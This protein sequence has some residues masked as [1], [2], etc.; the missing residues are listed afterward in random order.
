M[1]IHPSI[2]M[3][4]TIPEV[5]GT[6]DKH[7]WGVS[8]SKELEDGSI[9]DLLLMCGSG[10]E[11]SRPKTKVEAPLFSL[12]GKLTLEQVRESGE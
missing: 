3:F 8:K 12:S 9:P 11:D 7:F 4:T 2:K 10:T 6:L 1:Q 5:E